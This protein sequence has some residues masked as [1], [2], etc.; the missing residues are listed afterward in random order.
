MGVSKARQGPR[1]GVEAIARDTVDL[2]R[3]AQFLANFGDEPRAEDYWRRRLAFWWHENPFKPDDLPC[4]WVA[5]HEGD[6][7]GFLAGLHF[8]YVFR[9][10]RYPAVNAGTWRVLKEHRNISLPMLNNW[11]R[12]RDRAILIDTTP[13]DDV[14]KVLERFKFASCTTR[15]NYFI[16]LPRRCG[17]PVGLAY[18]AASRVARWALPSVA[19]RVVTMA[20]AFTVRDE[21]MNPERLE[22]RISRAYLDWYCSWPTKRF[23]GCVD[24]TETLTSYLIVEPAQRGSRMLLQVIDYFT[25]RPNKGELFGLLRYLGANLEKL[26]LGQDFQFL[27]FSEVDAG[28]ETGDK[29]LVAIHRREPARHYYHVPKQLEGV[30]KRCVLA[31]GDY[32]C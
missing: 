7:V 29:P 31:E 1:T 30:P 19:S 8:E 13:N 21:C 18:G 25:T 2:D 10:E 16:P 32:G 26:S 28:L 14:T 9:G 11:R 24:E 17:G 5:W 15:H 27:V 12:L 6:V 22:K 4:G 23:L 3:I 20:D